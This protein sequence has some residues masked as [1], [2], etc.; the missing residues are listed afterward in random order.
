[1]KVSSPGS[2]KRGDSKVIYLFI[3]FGDCEIDKQ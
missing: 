2:H 3:S 1:M